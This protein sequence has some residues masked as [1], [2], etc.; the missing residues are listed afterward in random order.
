LCAAGS[1]RSVLDVSGRTILLRAAPAELRGR[2]FGLLEG[3][4]MLGLASGSILVPPLVSLS[5]PSAALVTVGVL[6]GA[7]AL[8]PAT[9]LRRL[10]AQ[11]AL[12]SAAVEP[13]AVALAI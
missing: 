6:L 5:S 9:K 12:T 1:S 11:S 7:V 2:V 10:D 8:L 13:A 3:V 4:A